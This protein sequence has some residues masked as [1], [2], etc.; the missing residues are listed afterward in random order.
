MKLPELLLKIDEN[1]QLIE[2]Y[3]K[4]DEKILKK[5]NY[6]FRLD[7][8]YYSN[9]MEGNSLT[10]EETRSVMMDVMDIGGKSFKD[11][12]E[13]RGH[14]N[15]VLETLRIG[16]GDL[17]LSETRIKNIHKAI[18][19]EEDPEKAKQ[20]GQW[21]TANNHLIN[22]RGEKFDFSPPDRVPDEMHNLINW[23]NSELNVIFSGEWVKHPV[24]VA[25]EFHI[26][27]L[28]IHP[29][30]DGNG[31]TARILSNLILIACG[32]PPIIIRK[33]EKENIYYKSL[34]DIQAY[35]GDHNVFIKFFAEKVIESQQ[36]VL[37]AIAGKNID[38]PDDID[39]RIAVLKKSLSEED[40]LRIKKDNTGIYVLLKEIA[41]PIFKQIEE[42]CTELTDLFLDHKRLVQS[43]NS[44]RSRITI[45]N[46]EGTWD[47]FQDWLDRQYE[48]KRL[49]A[50]AETLM[51]SYD[52][53][54][55]KKHVEAENLQIKVQFIFEPFHYTILL[56][57]KPEIKRPYDELMTS[58]EQKALVDK[59]LNQVLDTIE[60]LAKG[61]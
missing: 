56:N 43:I 37:D 4:F 22:Y 49:E 9:V 25:A 16:K 41:F 29:F 20:V 5:I 36:M 54:G 31:R 23:L 13:M 39:K 14:D 17:R 40:K 8:N 59:A 12:R 55:F 33:E 32:Y 35:G 34:A 51:F 38:E 30:F 19:Y 57:S 53:L 50:M 42:K 45:V 46:K 47:H 18:V 2:S 52:L 28:T 58:S 15:I 26:V 1:Q 61:K 27:Y 21:K 7:W 3:G 10:K 6:K 44:I 60:Y 11:V 48:Q 24:V